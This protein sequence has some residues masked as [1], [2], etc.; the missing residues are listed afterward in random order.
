MALELQSRLYKPGTLQASLRKEIIQIAQLAFP[1]DYSQAAQISSH[2]D[3]SSSFC[4]LTFLQKIPVAFLFF[5]YRTVLLF[6]KEYTFLSVGPV[7]TDVR[8]QKKGIGSQLLQTLDSYSLENNVDM[9][10]L[11][12]I[13]EFYLRFGFYPFMIKSKITISYQNLSQ[14]IDQEK[15]RVIDDLTFLQQ[16][17]LPPLTY[18]SSQFAIKRS[19]ADWRWL[20][21]T[22]S[23]SYY[24]QNPIFLS[25]SLSRSP[26]YYCSNRIGNTVVVRE[27]H[28]NHTISLKKI[29]THLFNSGNQ[30]CCFEL[31]TYQNSLLFRYLLHRTPFQF[32]CF[33]HPTGRALM[34]IVNPQKLLPELAVL[35]KSL[36]LI[37]GSSQA[38]DFS[39]TLLQNSSL[40]PLEYFLPGLIS[41]LWSPKTLVACHRDKTR[42]ST[43]IFI[44]NDPPFLYQGD[45]M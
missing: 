39:S 38:Y 30:G 35:S 42:D 23:H 7:A 10:I 43:D 33:P 1:S 2:F 40:R 44:S 16:Y 19:C 17:N 25:D 3:G 45:A 26:E 34:K 32:S 14:V 20:L 29:L 5:Q 13:P 28:A 18:G 4:L 8:Y 37:F 11:S 36:S 22:H 9:I 24:F 21:Q 27:I 6:G 41:G 31:F 15:P 12:G